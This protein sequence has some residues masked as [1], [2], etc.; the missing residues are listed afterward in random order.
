VAA[1]DQEEGCQSNRQVG[2]QVGSPLSS[3]GICPMKD[4]GGLENRDPRREMTG[5]TKGSGLEGR[6]IRCCGRNLPA[7]VDQSQREFALNRD[8]SI[9]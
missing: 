7:A 9:T 1:G 6:S 5:F 2:R 8:F 4:F 3:W